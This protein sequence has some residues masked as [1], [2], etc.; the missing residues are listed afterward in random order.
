MHDISIH[1]SYNQREI[2]C[3]CLF[4]WFF[5]FFLLSLGI[6]RW[7]YRIPRKKTVVATSA[8][9]PQQP[10]S[11]IHTGHRTRRSA[12]CVRKQSWQL[13]HLCHSR[14]SRIIPQNA[15]KVHLA[16]E[17]SRGNCSISATWNPSRTFTLAQRF[18]SLNMR[19]TPA[20]TD[21]RITI[22]ANVLELLEPCFRTCVSEPASKDTRRALS[23]CLPFSFTGA[24]Y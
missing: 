15:G 19:G 23:T 13:L 24:V 7:Q 9:Q 10:Q 1:Q 5:F 6:E 14:P 16:Q 11:Y 4:V 18:K 2:F 21:A 3:F 20:S 17:N 12:I 8:F 22:S